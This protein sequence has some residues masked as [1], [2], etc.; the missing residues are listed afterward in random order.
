MDSRVRFLC[1][2]DKQGSRNSFVPAADGVA[3]AMAT[4]FCRFNDVV[5][6][7]ISFTCPII[8]S[9]EILIHNLKTVFFAVEKDEFISVTQQ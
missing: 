3:V 2:W 7:T 9:N 4:P 1:T 6:L 5:L 8:S